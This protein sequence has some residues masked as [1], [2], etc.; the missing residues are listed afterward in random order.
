MCRLPLPLFL[1]L[2]LRRFFPDEFERR[3]S[4]L[5]AFLQALDLIIV[6]NLSHSARE[7]THV[8][9]ETPR[10]TP[11]EKLPFL[12]T[13]DL[14]SEALALLRCHCAEDCPNGKLARKSSA[15]HTCLSSRG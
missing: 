5:I 13:R 2:A 11:I 14:T 1:D 7:F 9:T 8:S 3:L 10:I 15:E 4:Q 12:T 6:G